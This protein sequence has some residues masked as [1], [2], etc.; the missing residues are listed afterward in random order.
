MSERVLVTGV[1]GCLGAWAARTVLDGGDEIVGFDPGSDMSRLELVLG[2]LAASVV[3]VAGDVTD[4]AQVERV[5]DEHEV[6]RVVHLAG[7]QVPFC[8]ENPPLGRIRQRRRH[9]ERARGGEAP[10]GQHPRRG[11]CV[12]GRGVRATRPIAGAGDGWP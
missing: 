5:L 1:L 2:P 6:T 3:L 9:R 12:F 4:L 7:L 8:R 11:I 10:T